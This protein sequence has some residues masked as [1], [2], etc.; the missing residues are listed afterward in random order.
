MKR[1]LLILSQILF[2]SFVSAQEVSKN[3]L[4]EHFTNTFCGI[5]ASRNPTLYNT[6]DSYGKV[7]HVA[8]H[9][10]S[11]FP[12]CP[13]NQ[14]NMAENDSRTNYYGIYGGTPRVVM[15]GTVIPAST[16]LLSSNALDGQN[17]ETTPFDVSAEQ[18]QVGSDSM[19]TEITLSTVA[20]TSISSVIK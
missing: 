18:F 7:V 15:N 13:L 5:C 3:I 14:H 17:N 8:Y 11:P 9:P 1:N 6:L 19:Y 10:S 4:V 20:A 12:T 16:T 2:L